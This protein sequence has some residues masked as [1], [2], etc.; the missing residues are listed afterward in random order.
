MNVEELLIS[1]NIPYKRSGR[2]YIISCLN[3]EHKD[4]HP[5]LRVD[6]YTGVMHCFSCGF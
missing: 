1:K 4:K 6:K 2:D 3:T 5:S